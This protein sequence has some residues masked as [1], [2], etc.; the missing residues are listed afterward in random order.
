MDQRIRRHILCH[1]RAGCN[2][3]TAPYRHWRNKL[4]IAAHR[5]IILDHR[6]MLPHTVIVGGDGPRSNIHPLP[7]R[8]SPK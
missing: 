4:R 2:V 8:A 7:M 1:G 6:L 5:H 3:C